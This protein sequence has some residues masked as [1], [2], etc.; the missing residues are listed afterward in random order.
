[1]ANAS[2][3]FDENGDGIP[4]YT[5]YNYQKDENGR[6]D[7]R[8]IGKWHSDLSL[9]AKD[10]IWSYVDPSTT[11]LAST[12]ILS[13]SSEAFDDIETT[14]AALT[15][16][17]SQTSAFMEDFEEDQG[18]IPQSV[19]SFPC[20]LGEI[21]IMNTVIGNVSGPVIFDHLDASLLGVKA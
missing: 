1:M 15:T 9:D 11:T 6:S 18:R 5:I 12:T 8:V 2:V 21:M 19:C 14:T 17:P 4:R 3:K 7:Y 13:T 10:V 20:K 16:W